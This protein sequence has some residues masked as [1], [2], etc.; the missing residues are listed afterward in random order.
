MLN[1]YYNDRQAYVAPHDIKTCWPWETAATLPSA[2]RRKAFRRPRGEER[3]GAYRGGRPLATACYVTKWHFMFSCKS[4]TYSQSARLHEFTFTHFS[5]F[6]YFLPRDAMRKHG[7]CCR[8]VSVRPSVCVRKAVYT[9]PLTASSQGSAATDLRGGG[10]FILSFLC[11]SF[12]NLTVKKL[13]KLFHFC[14]SYRRNWPT[15][16]WDTVYKDE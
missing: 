16:F 15:F 4:A 10:S 3:A 8:P 11:R 2:R 6:T 13:W 9:S 7:L 5:R 14:R 1:G 12:L